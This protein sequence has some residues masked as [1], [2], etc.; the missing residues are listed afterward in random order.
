M[1]KICRMAAVVLLCVMVLSAAG[2]AKPKPADRAVKSAK[3]PAGST[4]AE[5][6]V[7]RNTR[8]GFDFALPPSWKGYT[9][10]ADK[11]EGMAEGGTEVVESGPQISIRSP[12]WTEA[13]PT[14]DIPIMVFTLAQWSKLE[15]DGFHIG[16]APIGPA[17][18]G[19]NSRYVF[20]LPA[21][22]NY[23]FPAGYREVEQILEGK[24]LKPTENFR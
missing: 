12:K 4:A 1:K 24:P 23:A 22:Y 17:E 2:C 19:R 14:Q 8:Y 6:V 5:E 18:L 21:R 20:A 16:A 7:Y 13:D 3:P 15:N 11:W 9:I 10:I